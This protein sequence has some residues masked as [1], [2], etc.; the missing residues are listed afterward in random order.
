MGSRPTCSKRSACLRVGFLFNAD[1]NVERLLACS[2]LD[3]TNL[4]QGATT[5][6]D[7]VARAPSRTGAGPEQI[8]AGDLGLA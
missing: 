3:F 2:G 6:V 5:H 8:P 1:T 7:R 4:F